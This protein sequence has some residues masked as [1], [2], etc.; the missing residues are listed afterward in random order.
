MGKEQDSNYYNI[1]FE[2]APYYHKGWE[3]MGLWSIIWEESIVTGKQIGRAH[4]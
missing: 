3:D 1:V 4:V 2:N